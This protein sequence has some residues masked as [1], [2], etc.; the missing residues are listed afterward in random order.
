MEAKR[1]DLVRNVDICMQVN[2]FLY[3]IHGFIWAFTVEIESSRSFNIL[4]IKYFILH[5]YSNKI[6]I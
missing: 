1:F 2:R 5:I 3:R 6:I 4:S